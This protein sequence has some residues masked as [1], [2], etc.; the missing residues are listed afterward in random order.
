MVGQTLGRILLA[1]KA[2][3]EQFISNNIP[4]TH[5]S[6]ERLALLPSCVVG[7]LTCLDQYMPAQGSQSHD[8]LFHREERQCLAVVQQL[9]EDGTNI[10][11]YV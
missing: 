2:E 11:K 10:F 1:A 7:E 5:R 6:G 9:I 8:R 4:A 3:K